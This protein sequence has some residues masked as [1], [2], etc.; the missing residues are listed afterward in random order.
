MSFCLKGYTRCEKNVG[1][2]R[3]AYSVGCG[4]SVTTGKG[5]I[6]RPGPGGGSDA[7]WGGSDVKTKS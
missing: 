7:P 5:L 1:Y 4:N 3:L 6:P 2:F